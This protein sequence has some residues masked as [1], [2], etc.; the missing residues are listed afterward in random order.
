[1]S[2]SPGCSTINLLFIK[3][4]FHVQRKTAQTLPL[5]VFLMAVVFSGPAFSVDVSL[6]QGRLEH[7][8]YVSPSR[9]IQCDLRDYLVLQSFFINDS[10][11]PGES[12]TV[13]FGLDAGTH[14]E[15]WTV[16]RQRNNRL[17]YT[18][19]SEDGFPVN[20]DTFIP[21]FYSELPYEISSI[22]KE[23]SSEGRSEML[24]VSLD[25][26]SQLHAYWL[27]REHNSL[28]SIQFIPTLTLLQEDVL[29]LE[30]VEKALR[31]MQKRCQFR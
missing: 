7:G 28:T 27:K 9:Q 8:S 25:E 6:L 13:S 29:G 20:G 31:E 22:Y 2:H 3:E 5:F 23:E 11:D 4:E 12:E 26:Q 24:R 17:E 18:P 1:M 21:Y 19:M 14:F 30:E 15:L 10:Y 16:R